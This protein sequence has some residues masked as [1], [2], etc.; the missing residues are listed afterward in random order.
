MKKNRLLLL[1]IFSIF[2]SVVSCSK[3]DDDQP[4]PPPT[5]KPSDTTGVTPIFQS[6]D[7]RPKM[8]NWPAKNQGARG[9]CSIFAVTGMLEFE[10]SQIAGKTISL[11]EEY[12]NWAKNE[13]HVSRGEADYHDGSYFH[14]AIYGV[15][16]S[17][18]C[19][20]SLMPYQPSWDYDNRP[21]PS[22]AAKNDAATR[23]VKKITW[24]R[25]NT[26]VKGITALQLQQIKTYL[27]MGHPVALGGNWTSV[28]DL[29][30]ADS[31]IPNMMRVPVSD[32]D[33]LAGHSVLIMGFKD[34]GSVPGG[35][36][37]I[38]RNSWGE[39]FG[40]NGY[41]NMP[42]EYALRFCCDALT[43]EVANI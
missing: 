30:D 5:P 11:S 13:Y 9:T 39:T 22:Q 33:V 23:T 15:Q 18:I 26:G 6:A 12:N 41:A 8:T 16:E 7:L 27:K 40:D 3:G 29:F 38:F 43:V 37:F 25:E 36:Y 28:G 24:I 14:W 34:D 17:G 2:L 42:Y 21:E 31:P 1:A 10:F 4:T 19:L 35:G 32:E 20:E